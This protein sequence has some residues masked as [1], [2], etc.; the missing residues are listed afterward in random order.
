MNIPGLAKFTSELTKFEVIGI[1][2]REIANSF[3]AR[4]RSLVMLRDILDN[5]GLDIPIHIFGAITP[6]EVLA[7]F[8]S[9]ADV[10]DGLN[11]LRLS[12]RKDKLISME[13]AA[14]ETM[15]WDQYD[16]DLWL[17]EWAHN[18]AYLYEMQETM[19]EFA[20][21]GNLAVFS[22]VFP[23]ASRAARIA[24]I[25]GARILRGGKINGR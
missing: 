18:L 5:F 17:D 1:T 19:R 23:M 4:C 9:G 10:F 22:G 20:E 8:F 13:Q 6:Y 3:L 14:F 2:A 15:E 25:A 24:E 7:Y 16:S 21:T 11:W 12:Y